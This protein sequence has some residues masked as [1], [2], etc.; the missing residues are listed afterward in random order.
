MASLRCSKS[1]TDMPPSVAGS[2]HLTQPCL[3][4]PAFRISLNNKIFKMT[5]LFIKFENVKI[6]TSEDRL[7]KFYKI[8][9]VGWLPVRKLQTNHWKKKKKKKTIFRF[10]EKK[11]KISFTPQQKKKTLL[12]L[13]EIAMV[14]K[15]GSCDSRRKIVCIFTKKN[16]NKKL[17]PNLP[18]IYF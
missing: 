16:R 5:Y 11:K 12:C 14:T 1:Y 8:W 7:I 18:I 10:T 9:L 3:W 13:K 17:S 15:S 2:F 6:N 4:W